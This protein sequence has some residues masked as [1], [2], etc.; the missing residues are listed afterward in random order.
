MKLITSD[1]KPGDLT[2]VPTP[3]QP[4]TQ[5]LLDDL[6]WTADLA[7]R[8]DVVDGGVDV[9]ATDWDEQRPTFLSLPQ[10]PT[11]GDLYEPLIQW[12]NRWDAAEQHNEML[13]EICGPLARSHPEFPIQ[14]FFEAQDSL[15]NL[16]AKL[17]TLNQGKNQ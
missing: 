2:L 17:Q 6:W 9:S 12:A 3:S 16:A 5:D 14:S 15:Q 8:A 7:G 1:P 11:M 4:L 10:D 13:D